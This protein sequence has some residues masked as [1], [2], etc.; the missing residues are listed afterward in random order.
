MAMCVTQMSAKA[1]HIIFYATLKVY[2]LNT[3][4][5]LACAKLNLFAYL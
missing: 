4:L 3:Y 1:N 2:V 5:L